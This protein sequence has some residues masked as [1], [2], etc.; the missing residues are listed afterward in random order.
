MN[1]ISKINNLAWILG[2]ERSNII[3]PLA[4]SANCSREA[5]ATAAKALQI[6][7]RHIYKLI[8]SYRR[9]NGLTTSLIPQKPNGGKGKS[10][11]SDIQETLINPNYG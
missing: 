7:S 10:R 11:L 1:D 8:H 9:S 2:K 6:S 4:E 5:I 3:R